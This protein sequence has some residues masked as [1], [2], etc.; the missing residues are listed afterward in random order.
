MERICTLGLDLGIGSCGW[1]VLQQNT[2]ETEGEIR[3]LG[4]RCFEVPETDKERKLKNAIRREKRGM[5]KV[6][7]RRAQR[8]AHLR[9]Y[10]V[11]AGILDKDSAQATGTNRKKKEGGTNPWQARVKGLS[12]KLTGE[13]LAS[14]LIHIARHRGFRSNSKSGGVGS[15][16]AP[17][18]KQKAKVGMARMRELSARYETVG[19]LL[20]LDEEFK[21]KKRN[22]DGDYSHTVERKLHEEEVATLLKRQKSKGWSFPNGFAEKIASLSFDQ[23]PLKD[24]EDKVGDC[25]FEK[26]EKR[27]PLC[28]PTF[29]RFRLLSKLVNL[30]LLSP[31][32]IKLAASDFGS[33][34]SMTWAALRKKISLP[35]LV[36]LPTKDESESIFGGKSKDVCP[37]TYTL[38]NAMPTPAVWDAITPEKRDAIAS[39]L[40]FREQVESIEQGLQ[41]IGLDTALITRLMEQVKDGVF[42]K[43]SKTGNLSLKAMRNLIPHL[44]QGLT[45]DKACEQVGYDHAAQKEYKLEDLANPVVQRIVRE[46][47]KQVSV[48]IRAHG[49]PNAIHVE[50]ARDI[51]KSA[52]ER[53]T[54]A[55]GLEKRRSEKDK[56]RESFKSLLN[57]A[58]CNDN[59]LEKYELWREQDHRC[60]Y[61][62]NPINQRHLPDG[63]NEL[64]VDHILPWSRSSDDSF[65]NR[66]L[67]CASCNQLKGNKTPF[68]WL[69]HDEQKWPAFEARVVRL[70]LKGYK[71]RNLLMKNFD[72]EMENRFRSR[73]LN[74]T[75]YA[76]RVILSLLRQKY[77][78][79]RV[80]ARPGAI[81]AL[82]RK[83]WGLERIK[84]DE[85][86]N[87]LGDRH[88]ALD[89][90]IVAATSEGQLQ[91]LTKL[92]QWQEAHGQTERVPH[93]PLPWP[94]F[95]DELK[96]KLETVFVSRSE[97]G[98]ARGEGHE[99]TIRQVWKN[100]QK[101]EEKEA[102]YD[103]AK[104]DKT[105]KAEWL[106]DVK[107][108]DGGNKETVTAIRQWLADGKPTPFPL[109]PRTK[110]EIKK[111]SL[112][113]GI[114][115]GSGFCLDAE[116]E[117]RGLGHVKNASMVR[118]DVFERTNGTKR[119]ENGFYFV[120][121]YTHQVMDE[122]KYPMPHNV[123]ASG[124]TMTED[125]YK[126]LFTLYPDCYVEGCDEDGV[127]KGG[128]YRTLDIDDGSRIKLS[129]Q[130]DHQS[131]SQF[132]LSCKNLVSF[133]KF[134]IDRLG[135]KHEIKQ[136][137][138]TWHGKGLRRNSEGEWEFV[139]P[140]EKP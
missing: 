40:S 78:A 24:S 112:L 52:E 126:F 27:A 86:G 76:C 109:H 88:H 59:E 17:D 96:A 85:K 36:R 18:E 68:E 84:K 104:I 124:E 72:E 33:Q 54:L 77:P 82:V 37:G 94:H 62:D 90:C 108:K 100:E 87:R 58:D 113:S 64:Q 22:T 56:N 92:W 30:K 122:K 23:R 28:S 133:R 137:Q 29:E 25:P 130:E 53:G 131:K 93:V 91:R 134:H 12:E 9:A 49:M 128:Y 43:F 114:K 127:V 60:L 20:A 14:A 99:A 3:E 75:R 67:C 50:M 32:Q 61:C 16:E 70:K 69:G 120:P 119:G 1:G 89:A 80:S 110:H 46:A 7:R 45:Y 135:N 102:V 51:G 118:V 136:E 95:A 81:T 47:L 107:D 63:H 125:H 42:A 21:H 116:G 34:K 48:I 35:A 123:A 74:D 111:I 103:R 10:L 31:E 6:T 71:K 8:M 65:T 26:G 2:E 44:E 98:R 139:N 97:S 5:R 66:T 101:P 117:G 79:V 121:I 38:K 57:Q 39:V 15:N 83:S 19:A 115:V 106:D 11:E 138:R 13:E 129:P 140:K 132:R 105:F 4:S 41:D 55:K 73:N